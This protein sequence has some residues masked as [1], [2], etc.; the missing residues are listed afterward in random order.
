M[1]CRRRSSSTP[2]V[3]LTACVAIPVCRDAGHRRFKKLRIVDQVHSTFQQ[4]IEMTGDA[5]HV[6]ILFA[7]LVELPL[8]ASQRTENLPA[9]IVPIVWHHLSSPVGQS[10]QRWP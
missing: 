4:G 3:H 9:G 8:T 7:D 5:E 6:R 2:P 10:P 1:A